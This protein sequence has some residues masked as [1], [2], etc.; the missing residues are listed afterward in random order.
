MGGTDCLRCVGAADAAGVEGTMTLTE[1]RDSASSSLIIKMLRPTVRALPR[2]GLFRTT[3]NSFR[4]SLRKALLD[5]GVTRDE[6]MAQFASNSVST[7]MVGLAGLTV[8]G[9]L[10]IDTSPIITG[11]G[12]SGFA[13]GFAMKEVAGNY[14]SG[15]MLVL[16]KSFTTGQYIKVHVGS[17][18]FEGVVMSVD[19]RHVKLLTNKSEVILI[20]STVV[21]TNPLTII[22]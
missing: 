19:T 17:T 18:V 14:L 16:S 11:L 7:V 15:L 2:R 3:R 4:D 20:P 10:G 12:V 1:S 22:K 21:Y 5:Y 8:L 6:N 13:A 9:T